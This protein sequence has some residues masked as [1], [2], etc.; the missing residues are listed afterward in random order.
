V[1]LP[2]NV[3]TVTVTGTFLSLANGAP[4]S[5]I[6]T[7]TPVPNHLLDASADTILL[8]VP[9]VAQLDSSGSLSVTL[10]A[11]DDVDLNPVNW[12]YEVV[13]K[14]T[15]PDVG[16][17][18][19]MAAPA[20]SAI[21][22]ADV[23]PVDG[24]GGEALVTVHGIPAGGGTGEVLAKTSSADYATTWVPAS[25]PGAHAVTHAAGSSDPVSL[26]GSQVATFTSALKGVVPASG[27]GT[28]NYLRADGTW[29]APAGGGGAGVTD[30]DK[31]DIVVSGSGGAWNIDS[32]VITS[33][34]RTVLDDTTVAAMRTSLG[35]P[36]AA[37]QIICNLPLQG[38]TTLGA[39]S[40]ILSISDFT[41]SAP[42]TVPSPGGTST[43]RFLKDDGTWASP[44]SAVSGA[45]GVF[46]FTYN[47]STLETI[48]GSQLRGNAS[49][50]T[51]STKLWISETTLDGLDVAIGLGRV[52]AGFQVYV[53]DY[54]SSTRYAVFN[55]TA[56]SVDKGT[57]WEIAVSLASSAGII[58]GGKVAYQ[59]LTPI[60]H[61]LP[62]GGTTGQALT[63]TSGTDWAAGWSN[64]P[65][66]LNGLV[67]VWKGTAAQYAAIATKDPNTLY[68]VTA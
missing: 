8:G 68:A 39:G 56:D 23:I 11:T 53:Q 15:T 66:A 17:R 59:T 6:V 26:A 14:L 9:I 42:G 36:A 49:T 27:G 30:G 1:T 12:T 58:P 28:T 67:A 20:G 54:T 45:A 29:A 47:T 7:F 55:V 5:G 33:V 38:S 4:A 31:G 52:K 2:T 57:Y 44:P 13:V 19:N 50:F 10:A 24:S 60:V 48:T 62:S 25:A 51:A 63:K 43:G 21:D 16:W 18:F 61:G 37:T 40:I 65:A 32:A 64:V 3:G 46:P 22:M 35:V 34:A 41:V